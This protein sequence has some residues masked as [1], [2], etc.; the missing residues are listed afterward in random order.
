MQPPMDQPIR[1]GLA[2]ATVGVTVTL[3]RME[4]LALAQTMEDEELLIVFH[5]HPRRPLVRLTDTESKLPNW[6]HMVIAYRWVVVWT[7]CSDEV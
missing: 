1:A 3:L 4:M 7:F 6:R 5:R 2:A